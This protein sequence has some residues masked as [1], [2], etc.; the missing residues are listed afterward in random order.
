VEKAI[1][2]GADVISM[3]LGIS[4]LEFEDCYEVALSRVVEEAVDAGLIVVVAAG[5]DYGYETISAPGCAKEVITVGAVNKTDGIAEFS[6]RGPV[7]WS[8]GTLAKPDVVAPGVDICAAQWDEAWADKECIDTI[9]I[10]LS[11]TSMATPH[12]AGLAAILKQAYPLWDQ[13]TFK[14]AIMGGATDLGYDS[15]TQGAGRINATQSYNVSVVTYPQ[16][17]ESTFRGEDPVEDHTLIIKNLRNYEISLTLTPSLARDRYDDTFDVASLNATTLALSA[18]ER[19]AVQVTLNLSGVGGVVFGVIRIEVEGYIHF[20]PYAASWLVPLNITVVAKDLELHP[21]LC[22][23]DDEGDFA[24]C[25]SQGREFAGNSYIFWVYPLRNYTAYADGDWHNYSLQYILA[26][27]TEVM[28]DALLILNL[29]EARA[30]TV[31][32]EALDGA[33]LK[34]YTWQRAFLTYNNSDLI[35]SYSVTDASFIQEYGNL[36]VYLS[37]KPENPLQTDIIFK[38][39]GVPVRK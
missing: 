23:H 13:A 7:V 34:L 38:Y 30:F 35:L 37:N 5:N 19:A 39:S 22:V 21:D 12:V 9:H 17:L 31:M 20:V 10:S 26:N 3:S 28:Y 36:T 27:R 1:E 8:N 2:D 18:G 29:S 33:P 24:K 25:A 4:F 15:A 16:S 32:A 14:S 11:G 6:S